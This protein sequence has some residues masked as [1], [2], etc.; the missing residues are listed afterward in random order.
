MKKEAPIIVSN[1]ERGYSVDMIFAED[2]VNNDP[3]AKTKKQ[4]IPRT[5]CYVESDCQE[6]EDYNL[7]EKNH[8][9]ISVRVW[10]QKQ[11]NLRKYG[12]FLTNYDM[13]SYL[14][15]A[16]LVAFDAGL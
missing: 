7:T 16:T 15:R 1:L 14:S 11:S 8:R 13:D 6:I 10:K 2:F 5:E 3:D 12:K 9:H 4:Y